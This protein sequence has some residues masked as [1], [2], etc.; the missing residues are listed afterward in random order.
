[1]SDTGETADFDLHGFVAI[2]LVGG[3][4]SDVLAVERQL[5]PIRKSFHRK[6]DIVIRFVPRIES[7]TLRLLGVNEVAYSESRFFVLRGAK[8]SRVMVDLP[9]DQIGKQIT[10]T[11]ES[12][13]NAVP[14]LIAIVNM[15][16]LANGLVPLHAAAFVYQGRGILCTGWSKG[17]KTETLLGFLANGAKYLGDEWVYLDGQQMYGIPEPIHVWDWHLNAL[18]ETRARLRR[19]DRLK[20][21]LARAGDGIISAMAKNWLMPEGVRQLFRRVSPFVWKQRHVKVAPERLFGRDAFQSQASID[22]VLL[23]M[24]HASD[25]YRTEVIDVEDVAR[26]MVHSLQE[27]RADLISLHEHF[28]FA[29]PEK[30]NEWIQTMESVQRARLADYLSHCK[31]DLVLHPYPVC[32][33]K[34]FDAIRPIVS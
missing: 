9:V 21:T 15:T 33:V 23:V 27:E 11:C 30:Q 12:G 3:T 22:R 26:R 24:S 2:R 6:P 32:P 13:L 1:M 19:K 7:G 28:R 4:R 17:G 16:A 8:K 25:T 18:P 5:G 20:L 34:L 10:I 14:Y 31:A 29:F